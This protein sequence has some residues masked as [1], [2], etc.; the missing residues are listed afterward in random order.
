MNTTTET[1]SARHVFEHLGKPP[2]R[3][4]G[5][6]VRKYQACH[7]APIQC[8]AACDHCAAGIMDC[9]TFESADGRRFKVGS[10]C[11]EKSGDKGMYSQIKRQVNRVKTERRHEREAVK[12]QEIRTRLADELVRAKLAALPH[13]TAFRAEKGETLL[14]WADWMMANAG[15]AGRLQVGRVIAKVAA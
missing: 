14:S 11:V 12:V 2:Y 13:P 4:V 7:G 5:F 6:D 9:Y 3:F 10:T 1:V 8:G 15:N